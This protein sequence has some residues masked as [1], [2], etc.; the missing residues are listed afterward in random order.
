MQAKCWES[1]IR[2]QPKRQGTWCTLN[3]SDPFLISTALNLDNHNQTLVTVAYCYPARANWPY[4]LLKL[5]RLFKLKPKPMNSTTERARMLSK[6]LEMQKS[7][8]SHTSWNPTTHPVCHSRRFVI[9]VVCDDIIAK[10]KVAL[11]AY[12]VSAT[13]LTFGQLRRKWLGTFG[14]DGSEILFTLVGCR[15][16]A[17]H[18]W[19][20]LASYNKTATFKAFWTVEPKIRALVNKRKPR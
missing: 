3:S 17:T 15:N 8:E 18:F 20:E 13:S 9:E 12:G 6:Y 14:Q 5:T 11:A 1:Q 4:W 19:D 2:N 7:L 10:M 16:K